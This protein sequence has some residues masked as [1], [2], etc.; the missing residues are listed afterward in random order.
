MTHPSHRTILAGDALQR[1]IRLAVLV[2]LL[3]AGFAAVSG[4]AARCGQED[5]P[6]PAPG[7]GSESATFGRRGP[8]TDADGYARWSIPGADALLMI[9]AVD[10]NGQVWI[11]EM[12]SNTLEWFQPAYGRAHPFPFPVDPPAQTMGVV[13]DGASIAWLAQDGR[14]AIGR[15]DLERREYTEYPTPTAQSSPFGIALA[16]DGRVWFTEIAAHQIGVLDPA[17]GG[18]TE[19]PIPGDHTHPYWLAVAPDGRVWF[20][21]IT[22]AVVGVL[23]PASGAVRLLPVPGLDESDGTTGLTIAPDGAEW[24]GSREG[25]LGRIAPDGVTVSVQKTPA[26]SVYGV[27]ATEDGVIWAASPREQ[28]YGYRPETGAFCT[29]QTGPGAW[30]VTAAADGGLWVSEGVRGA[31]MLGRISA[32]RAAACG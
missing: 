1:A 6:A 2:A 24:F 9:P 22:A 5:G 14:H 4:L 11:G 32:E 12:G 25:S 30:W 17:N 21:V 13:V 19:Y 18:I 31:N 20:T 10:T 26:E 8:A 29:V 28:V 7:S 16:P 15:F 3:A 27:A 23:D